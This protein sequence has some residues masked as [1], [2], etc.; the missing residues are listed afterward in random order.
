MVTHID[1]MEGRSS[2]PLGHSD[3]VV[4]VVEFISTPFPKV[5][6]PQR[7]VWCWQKAILLKEDILSA[8]WS[9]LEMCQDMQIAWDHWHD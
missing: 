7:R 6:A 8:G 5:P 9:D 4:L 2:V 3:H 1:S